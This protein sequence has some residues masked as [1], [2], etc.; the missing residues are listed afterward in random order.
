MIGQISSNDLLGL[1]ARWTAS[2]RAMES[3]RSD[4]LFNDPWAAG[5]AGQKGQAW[6]EHRS[7]E[8]VLPMVIRTRY[9]D[10]FLQRITQSGYLRGSCFICPMRRYGKYLMR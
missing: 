2:V 1:T 10:D 4:C 7:A 5:L 3:K 9:F 8:S 6:I